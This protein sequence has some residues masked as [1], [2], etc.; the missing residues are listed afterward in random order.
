MRSQDFPTEFN[1][2]IRA[3][4]PLIYV[5][6]AEEERA[7]KA[8]EQVGRS[9]NPSREVV[10]YDLVHGFIHNQQAKNNLL[11]ALQIAEEAD[12]QVPVIF[13]F[14]D[15]HRRLGGQRPDEMIVR[16][17]RNLYRNLRSSRKTVVLLSPMLEVPSELEQQIAIL[18]F[19]LPNAD[20]IR[21]AIQ[22]M[23]ATEQLRLSGTGLEQLVK[24]CMGLTRDHIS[25]TLAKSLVQKQFISEA[26]IDLVLIEKQQR[27]RQTEFLEFFAPYETLD[28]IGGLD[29]FKQWLLQRQQAFSDEARAF[30]L[31]NPKGVL[32][33]GIQG[34]GKSLCAKA[35]AHLWRLPLL[36]LDVGKL[37]GSLVGQSESRTR[38]TIQLT[39]ALAPCVLWMDEIDK[40]FAGMTGG[41]ST[42]SGTSQ[43]VF[44]TLLTWMQ[45]K[46]TPVF[47]VATANNIDAL[48]PELLRKGRFDEIFFINLPNCEERKQI[49][50]VHLQR[51]RPT[52]LRKFDID[53][54]A[55]IAKEF[56]GAEIEQAIIEG[57]YRAFHHNRDLTTEDIVG[58]V[59]DTFP[60]ASTAREQ[61]NYMKAWAA[62]GRARSA[63]SGEMD[64]KNG[65][66]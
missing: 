54:M 42:D 16:Q 1:L 27:I 31:P 21:T 4:Y 9:C 28:S 10:Y 23:V 60:L 44:G 46:E 24:A 47:I 7:E 41:G 43:R 51:F 39:E 34:T 14:R 32:L 29:N 37:F 25:H 2:L 40:A 38:Q 26:D 52:E 49:F 30:G 3:K 19:P 56:S 13:V 63:S 8:I 58:A 50:S 15:L 36:R 11:Q 64:V 45:E 33:M 66:A 57:M 17:L 35:I 12:P 20:D 61:I 18:N 53:R 22:Q 6:T 5:V 59:Q 48:P 65:N 55:A 62:Q